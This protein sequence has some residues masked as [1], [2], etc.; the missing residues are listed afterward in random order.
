MVM[1]EAMGCGMPIVATDST[2]HSDII[3]PCDDTYHVTSTEYNEDGW[4]EPKLEDVIAGI[5]EFYSAER[6]VLKQY[7]L[8]GAEFIKNDLTWDGCAIDLLEAIG[9]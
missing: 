5:E 9:L 4:C 3:R 8:S 7:G 1:C 6:E 2:G